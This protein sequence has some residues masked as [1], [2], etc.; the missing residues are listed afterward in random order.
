MIIN[1]QLHVYTN[2]CHLDGCTANRPRDK[3]MFIKWRKAIDWSN[4]AAPYWNLHFSS[5]DKLRWIGFNYKICNKGAIRYKIVAHTPWLNS[6]NMINVCRQSFAESRLK[7]CFQRWAITVDNQCAI[8]LGDGRQITRITRNR[9]GRIL[10]SVQKYMLYH[11]M[12]L[13]FIGKDIFF[14]LEGGGV[15]LTQSCRN[16]INNPKTKVIYQVNRHC[17]NF[18]LLRKSNFQCSTGVVNVIM[19]VMLKITGQPVLTAIIPFGLA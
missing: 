3:L 18:V 10:N 15:V 5:I 7:K 11:H 13:G 19:A 16:P 9:P 17:S 14:S 2:I 8:S 12:L 6:L 4:N 1:I